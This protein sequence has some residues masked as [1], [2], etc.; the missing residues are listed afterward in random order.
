MEGLRRPDMLSF[1]GNTAE[2]WRVFETE[3]DIYIAAGHAD[4]SNKVKA[5]MLLNLAGPEAIEKSRAFT[6][7]P[8]RAN[9]EGGAE[10]PAETRDDPEVLK[11]KFSE[12]CNPITNVILER[13]KF[14]SRY[15]GETEPFSQFYTD[16]RNKANQCTYGDLTDE[17]LRDRIVAGVYDNSLR[18]QLLKTADLTL[19]KA[20]QLCQINEAA[21]SDMA[22]FKPNVGTSSTVDAVRPK[23]NSRLPSKYR[24][25]GSFNCTRCGG[26]HAYKDPCP[27]KGKR[28]NKCKKL[29]HF[30]S[31]CR[32]NVNNV[33]EV[34]EQNPTEPDGLLI[35]TVTCEQRS[36][37]QANITVCMPNNQTKNLQVKIDTGAKVNVISKATVLQYV[38]ENNLDKAARKTL[39]GFGGN[40]TQSLGSVNLE[41]TKDNIQHNLCFQVVPRCDNTLLGLADC[42]KLGFVTLSE[43]V[44]EV[45]EMSPT[46]SMPESVLEEYYDLFDD[47]LGTL[48]VKYKITVNEDVEPVIRPVRSVPIALK[49]KV[50]QALDKMVERGIITPVTEPTEW[51][52]A[53]VV[54]KKKN[55]D[56]IRICIDPGDLNRAIKR[57][58]H[59]LKTIEQIAAEI[60][61]A[62]YFTVVDAR[63]AFYHIP[64]ESRSSYLTTFGTPFGR[65]RYLRMPMGLC[66]S[67]DVY[68]RAI[69]QL[70]EGLPCH[71]IMD[72]ILITGSTEPEHDKN[73]HSVL[74]RLR[75][76]NLKLSARKCV[77]KKSEV[78]YIGHVLSEQGLKPDPAKVKAITEMKTPDD[79]QELLRFLGMTK[80]LSK[81]IPDLS[82]ITSALNQLLKKGVEWLWTET[83]TEAFETIKTKIA[84]A[85]TLTYYDVKKPVTLTCDAS[86]AGLGAACLQADKVVS[87]ASRAMTDTETR[88]S[89]IEKEMLAVVF[90]CS[91]FQDY[92]IGNRQVTVE[93]DHQPLVSIFRKPLNSAPARLQ[94]MLLQLQRYD[95]TLIY[96][97]GKDLIIADTL[98]RAYLPESEVSEMELDDTQVISAVSIT[99][100]KLEEL[101]RASANDLTNGKLMELSNKGWPKTDSSLAPEL[102]HYFPFRDELGLDDGVMYRGQRIIV[103]EILRQQY[104]SLLH[105][106]HIG[107]EGTRRRAREILYWPSMNADIETLITTCEICQTVRNHQPKTEVNNYPVPSRPFSVVATD[108][109]EWKNKSYLVTADSY[110]GWIE[111]DLLPT[112]SSTMVIN[113]LK[114]HFARF[115]SPVQ[116]ISDNGPQYV[117]K[118]FKMF[119]NSWDIEHITSAPTHSRSNGLA[120]RAVQ[121]IKKL[122][123]KT[124]REGGDFY[125]ALLNLRN[126][127]RDTIGSPAQR[128]LNRR[129]RPPM[130]MAESLLR[131]ELV[132]GEKVQHALSEKRT[133]KALQSSQHTKQLPAL[134]PGD[135]VRMEHKKGYGKLAQVIS[136]GPTDTSY[137]IQD[138]NGS[139]YRRTRQHL[140]KVSTPST[141]ASDYLTPTQTESNTSGDSTSSSAIKQAITPPAI[142]QEQDRATST[143]RP[144]TTTSSGRVVRHPGDAPNNPYVYYGKRRM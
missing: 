130:P 42:T 86:K 58:H 32:T 81:F 59:P 88:Y 20:V 72:D 27:A 119:T 18:R 115:G 38:D 51:V 21:E 52:S 84:S 132:D 46:I 100:S 67:S 53:L 76:I 140:L 1:E 55:C 108:I 113:K 4:K 77:Y 69:E 102:R 61:K 95:L 75:E 19:V 118:E 24:S 57:P 99:E 126:T 94:R 30:A 48:P 110:S 120:E 106:G 47:D 71:V 40:E 114:P 36:R 83:H 124:H 26:N 66:S 137:N 89:Q 101:Q 141:G 63:E 96:K 80:Y 5:M 11:R 22:A 103:P 90:A 13:H 129:T 93:T 74:E 15:Q 65:Y 79:K 125:L 29:N 62:K 138:S 7:L 70:L 123:E 39:I 2:N 139:V 85:T 127:P 25:S 131:P 135:T 43:D 37:A 105:Q 41:C 144:P 98:S 133:S 60:P 8:R 16:L 143:T 91:R 64:L 54:T 56:D 128:N 136:H 107:I 12:L 142:N 78:L 34:E 17:L 112:T 111:V 116:L 109:F 92:I 6:Y 23:P 35:E 31:M 28:C 14:N 134:Q 82:E 104:L 73:L 121:T 117:S 33:D 10:L 50:K 45:D 122:M 9:P 97:K 87:F 3:Y 68:Q 49:P 44:H